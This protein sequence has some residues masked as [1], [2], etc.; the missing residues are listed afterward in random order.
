MLKYFTHDKNNN[1]FFTRQM[2][3]RFFTPSLLSAIVLSL[4]N[5]VDALVVGSKMGETGLAALGLLA[6]V[7]MI[8]NVFDLGMAIGGS[9]H[10]TKLL[11]EGKAKEG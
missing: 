5:I 1:K 9:V 7:Y 6:P 2:F 8:F 3:Y 10:Y 11:G 4:G